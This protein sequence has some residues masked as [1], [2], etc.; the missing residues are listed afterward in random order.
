MQKSYSGNELTLFYPNVVGAGMVDTQTLLMVAA[1]TCIAV[2]AIYYVSQTRNKNRTRQKLLNSKNDILQAEKEFNLLHEG[3][4][5]LSKKELHDWK[6]RWS[7]LAPLIERRRKTG[8]PNGD[9]QSSIVRVA[10]IFVKGEQLVEKRNIEFVEKELVKFKDFFDSIESHPLTYGQRKAVVID[11]QSNLVVAG[12]GT[13]KTSTIVAKVGYLTK[14]GL[15]TPEGILVIAFNKDVVSEISERLRSELG[16]DFKVKTFHRLGLEI[17]AESEGIK[18]SVS[19][20][21]IDKVKLPRKILEFMGKRMGDKAFSKLVNEYY[22]YHFSPCRTIFEFNTL[23]D[24]IEYLREYDIRSLKGDVVKSY[25]ECD[26]ANFLYVNGIDYIYEQPYKVRTANLR[27]R[28]YK[29]DFFLPQYGLYIE[30][31]GIDRDGR[32]APFVSQISY[33]EEM[34]WKRDVHKEHKTTLVETYS[35]EKIEGKLLNNLE[36]RLR[37]KGVAFN[38]ISSEQILDKL[39]SMGKVDSLALLLSIFLNLYKSCGKTLEEI[40]NNLHH[41]DSR[42]R[43]LLEIFSKVLEDYTS[44]LQATGE[45][46]FNDMINKGANYLRQGKY[47]SKFQY[48]L[49]DEFQDISQSRYRLLKS[50]L[51][52]N[53]SKVFCV[54]DD[55]Q[56]VY[57]FTGSDL[58]IMLD[59]NKN[60][61]FG[62]MNC[63]EETFRFNDKLCDFSSKFVLQ[64]PNQIKKRITSRTKGN[65]PAVTVIKGTTENALQ[66][67]MREIDQRRE[68]EETVFIIARYKN[69]EPRNLASMIQKHPKLTVKFTTSHS[70]KGLE[71]DY[72]IMIGLTSGEYGFPCQIMDD[73]V[74]DLVLA[75][76][77]HYANAEERRLFYV[78]MTRARKHAYL[79]VDEN[80]PVSTFISEI[81]DND[82]EVNQV[83]K[84][85]RRSSCPICNTGSIVQRTGKYGRFYS[86]SNYPYCDYRPRKCPECQ[87]GFL[88]KNLSKYLCSDSRCY[89]NADVCPTCNEGY[90]TLRQSKY[91]EFYGCSNY[92][93]CNHIDRNSQRKPSNKD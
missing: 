67:I 41:Q 10:D 35:Y 86:C 72:V 24:Y 70:S 84:N 50:L 36:E 11:E 64:N 60:F 69:L 56:S 90:L 8:I 29:P 71:A 73:D 54:G 42:T 21:A 4:N 28:Q 53:G 51:D 9:F 30:H 45:I 61:E 83:G 2:C 46:D 52:Q 33:N 48:I 16:K 25:E 7:H 63:L 3:Q 58:S 17:V 43:K 13:G 44:Y 81:L 31:F 19:E 32:T 74:L 49:V 66:E 20:L 5:Y 27:H 57:R 92:P 88:Y 18:P 78:S 80:Y 76:Q 59:F 77:D 34:R 62:E 79:V 6:K 14:K 87:E 22:L 1:S 82:Y 39:N 23:G 47:Q 12:A 55:W 37:K 91:G 85:E 75:K 40:R 68:G 15:A 38:Q 89:F 26:I 93:E 65:A